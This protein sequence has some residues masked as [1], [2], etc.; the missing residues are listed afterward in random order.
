MD[1]KDHGEQPHDKNSICR[2]E[3][4]AAAIE[5]ARRHKEDE[6]REP[7]ARPRRMSLVRMDAGRR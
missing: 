7:P 1:A 6:Q 5:A 3:W 2:L 4:I